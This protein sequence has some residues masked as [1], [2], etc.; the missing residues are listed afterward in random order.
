MTLDASDLL[1]EKLDALPTKPGV[2]LMKDLTGKVLYVGKAVNLRARVRSYFHASAGRSPKI[3]RLVELIAD[4]DFIVTASELEALILE[5]NLIKRYKPRYNVRL[6]DDKRY[7]YIKVTWQED[8]PKVLIVRRM[9]QDGARYYGPFTASWAV[10]QTLHTLRRVFPYLT[11]NRTI[12]GEDDRACLYL[13]LGL[14]LGPCIG[15]TD[16]E[17]Y[18]AMIDGLCRFL[19]GK[20][21]EIV[22]GLEAQMAAAAEAWDFE[23]AAA[24]RDQLAAIQRVIERQ[25]IVTHDMADQDVI[26]FAREDGDACVQ[27][28]FIRNGRLIGR[29]YFVLDGAAEE[30]ASEILASFVKQFYDEAAYVPPEILLP[31]EIDEA[32]VIQR[33]LR[34]RRSG[35]RSGD[36]VS[37]T[38][39]REGQGRDLVE[40]AAEN[41]AETLAHLRAQWIADEGKQSAAL[42]ELEEALQLESPPNRIE[43]YDVSTIQG[44]ATTGSMVVFVK[45]VPRKS[46]Y[47]RFKIRTVEGSDDY[48]SMREMLRRRFRRVTEPDPTERLGPGGEAS[49]WDLLPNLLVVDGGKGQLNAALEVLDEFDLR[50]QV[51]A[52]G[53]AKREEE[54]FVPDQR[55]AVLLPRTSEGLYLLQRIRDEA[56]RFAVGYHRRVR[57]TQTIRS[58]LDDVPGIGPKR[59][60]ALL[61]HFGSLDAIRAASVEDLAA[62][63][64]M[65]RPAAEQVKEYL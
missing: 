41:A 20:S 19:E 15:A 48:A 34:E 31:H 11:C 26:A 38:V 30:S 9:E 65:T 46:D 8:F 42:A 52:V 29:E 61:K 24:F 37:V 39:P 7:P 51:P 63:P 21:D 28:F 47:R 10:Q 54:V 18:R 43:A 50:D 27:V 35:T 33:W 4:V 22:E 59:R 40:M 12:T 17:T 3:E 53:L 49:S 58:Q 32:L 64:G 36:T 16:R 55:D 14:C 13:D 45:G 57:R 2:Y 6:K 25:K 23:Q 5:S 1:K 60:S 44:S 62:V 56:H